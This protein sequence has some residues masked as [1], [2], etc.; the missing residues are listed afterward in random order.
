MP[1]FYKKYFLPGFVFQSIV[2][3]GGYG[4]GRELVEFFLT[5]GPAGGYLAMLLAALIW[6]VILALG[7]ELARMGQHYDYRTFLSA[8]LGRGWI[9]F[10]VLYILSVLLTVAVIGSASGELL[11]ELLGWPRI[12][13][14]LTMMALVG[15]LVYWGS[16]LI[17]R[18]FS[19]WSILLYAVYLILI[20]L[21]LGDHGEIILATAGVWEQDS[22]WV[23]GGLRYAAYNLAALP[24]MLFAVRHIETRREA[25]SAGFLASLIAMFP[26]ALIYTTFLGHYPAIVNEAIPAVFV[27][28]KLDWP[29]FQLA[30]QLILFGT[31]IET[32]TG[33]IHGFNER[34]AG[35]LK[36]RGRPMSHW[37]RLGIAAGVLVIAV[38]LADRFGLIALISEG[39]GLITWGYWIFFLLPVL[40]MG[41]WKILKSP[42]G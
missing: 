4:T 7:F 34:I 41:S 5:E 12:A 22:A 39:Y 2:I 31:F 21:V 20:V 35:A 42:A 3:G 27:L 30:F 23:M 14:T 28:S 9:G 11:H 26:G 8:L 25:L 13:G 15:L 24:A 33:M 16:G 32:G 40:V 1:T 10:E 38:W 17:E 19:V 29:F 36:E 37:L 18:V 6:G